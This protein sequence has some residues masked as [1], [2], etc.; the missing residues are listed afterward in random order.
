MRRPSD[1]EAVLDGP[2]PKRRKPLAP[3]P[4]SPPVTSTSPPYSLDE[5]PRN[6]LPSTYLATKFNDVSNQAG[7][8]L[9]G[10]R[11][12]QERAQSVWEEPRA[13]PDMQQDTDSDFKQR[14][15]LLGDFLQAF[16]SSLASW[17]D[18]FR[19]KKTGKWLR[20][21]RKHSVPAARSWERNLALEEDAE[22]LR[23]FEEAL[24]AIQR[25]L[26]CIEAVIGEE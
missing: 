15:N 18:H 9:Q 12:L 23:H 19:R 13:P 20:V 16:V 1:Q 3:A 21:K 22:A 17:K 5:S 25:D 6:S 14:L 10:A 7:Q 4:D 26:D 24:T 2:A 8:L 11:Q